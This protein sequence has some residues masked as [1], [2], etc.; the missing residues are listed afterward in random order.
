MRVHD[1]GEPLTWLDD[2]VFDRVALALVIHHLHDR[3]GALRELNRVLAADG[4]LVL[5]THHPMADWLNLGGSYFDVERIVDRWH[6]DQ[7]RVAYSRQPLD[8]TC[9]ELAA[10][11]FVIER[12]V[13]P[14]PSDAIRARDPG[15]FDRLS[16]RPDF[17]VFRL[18]KRPA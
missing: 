4:R 12:L 13:E 16:T 3:V 8:T 5:S 7:W 9:D 15:L 2:G 17:I 14:R 6:D 1:L 11:G 18:A 10:A